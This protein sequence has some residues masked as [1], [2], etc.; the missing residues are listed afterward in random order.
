MEQMLSPQNFHMLDV[1]NALKMKGTAIYRIWKLAHLD[2]E[3]VLV[4]L[5]KNLR[6]FNHSLHG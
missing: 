5:H 3:S 2:P 6:H 1:L 4:L